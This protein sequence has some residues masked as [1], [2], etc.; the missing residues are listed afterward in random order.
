[1]PDAVRRGEGA[2]LGD[3]RAWTSTSNGRD[4]SRIGATT[5]PG[6]GAS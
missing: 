4:P 2:P 5:L 1:M 6:A 3:T